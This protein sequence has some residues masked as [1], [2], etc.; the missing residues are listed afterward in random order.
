M[1]KYLKI[2]GVIGLG[3]LTLSLVIPLFNGN[4]D[5][6]DKKPTKE[7][8]NEVYL[9]GDFNNWNYKDKTYSLLADETNE[10]TFKNEFYFDEGVKFELISNNQKINKIKL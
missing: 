7:T 3:L 2:F 5:K 10:D 9:V 1:K 8:E 4:T 6:D